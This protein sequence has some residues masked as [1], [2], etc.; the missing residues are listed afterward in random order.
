MSRSLLFTIVLVAPLTA[1]DGNRLTYLDESDPYHV[2][3]AFPRLTTPQWVGEDGV[4]AVVVLAIDDMRGHEKWEAYLRPILNRLKRIDGRAPVSIM[5]C[6]IEPDEAHLQK[7]LAE[8]LSLETHT[9]DHPCPILQKGDLA[10][11]KATYDKCVDLLASVPGSKPVAFRTP[12]CDSLNTPSP[13][14]FAI[15]FNGTTAK[16]NYLTIDTSVFNIFTPDDPELPRELVLE[17]GRSRFAKYLPRD[18]AFGNLI[19]N[20]PYPY[21][22]GRLCWEFPCVTP[23]DWQAQHLHKPN[24]PLTIRDWQAAL[25]ATV[26]KQGVFCMVFHPHGWIKNEQVIDF[27]EHAVTRHGKKVKFL[28]FAECQKRLD[29]HLLG[30]QPLRSA[31][32]ADNGIRLLDLNGDGFMDVVIGND[33]VKQ[34]RIWDSRKKAW[35]TS[36]F[37]VSL[38]QGKA[39]FGIIDTYPVLLTHE[40]DRIA[41]WRFDGKKWAPEKVDWTS[42]QSALA[43]WPGVR[44]RDLD[45]DGTCELIVGMGNEG[46]VF[47]WDRGN[48][49]WSK[50]PFALPKGTAIADAKGNDAGL[51]F[52]DVDEDGHDDVLVSN[53]K[54]YGLWLFR[55]MKEGWSQE[56]C[57]GKGGGK[58][59]LP[60]IARNGTNNG[61]WFLDG[62]LWVQN[63]DTAALKDLVQRVSF[64]D[65]LKDVQPGPK[66]PEASQRCLK[67]SPGFLAELVAAE[68]LVQDPIA[69]AWGPDGKF[70]VVEMGDYPLGVDAKGRHGGRVKFLEDTDGDGKY[71]RSTVF[72]DGLGYPTGVTPWRQGV[73]VTCAPD[74]LYAEDLDGDGKADRRL[75]VYTGFGEGNQQHRVNTLAWGLDNWLHVANGDSD[76]TIRSLKSKQMVDIRGR[77]L[78]IRPDTGAVDAETG[79]TQF[80]RSRDD[81]GNWFGGNNSNPMWHFALADHYLR[82]NPHVAPPNLRVPVPAVPGNSPVFPR[83]RT[84]ARFNDYHTANRFTS[85]CSPIVYR[86]ELFGPAFKDNVFISEPVHNLVHREVMSPQG[87]TFRSTRAA[88]EEQA[89][90]LASSDNWFRP[91]MIRTG[92]DGA[93]W[94]ADM[95]RHVIEHPQWIPKDWQNRLD[96]RAGHDRGRIYRVYPVG[97]K[98]RAIPRF[99]RLVLADLVQVLDSPNG[100]QRD[101]VQQML[102]WKQSQDAIPMLVK[103]AREA[104]R[105]HTRLHALCTLDGLNA[106]SSALLVHVLADEHPGVRRHAVRL[107]EPLLA[108]SPE[109]GAALLKLTGDSDAQVRLQLACTLGEWD[110][111]QAGAGLGQLL[112]KDPDDP[113]LTT[114]AYSSVNATNL[115]ATLQAVLTNGGSPSPVSRLLRLADALGQKEALATLL[116]RV[117]SPTPEGFLPWQ[118]QALGGLLDN[119]KQRGTSFT[120]LVVKGPKSAEMQGKFDALLLAARKSAVD[121]KA[122]VETRSASL[123]VLGRTEKAQGED[124][125][126]FANLLVPRSPEGLQLAAVSALARSGNRKAASV[127]LERWG[128]YSPAI[129]AQVLDVLLQRKESTL[130]VLDAVANKQVHI[131]EIDTPRRQRLVDHRDTAIRDRA[132]KVLAG[133]I[134]LDRQKVIDLYRKEAIKGDI[135]RGKAVFSK[136]CIACHQFRGEGKPIGADL[137]SLTDKSPDAL[138]TAILDPNRAI[139]AKF[140]NY[141][142][143]MKDGRVLVGLLLSET[144]TSITLI[145][146]DGK[147]LVLLRN[148]LESLTSTGKSAMPEGFEK[149][150]KPQDVADVIAYL[151]E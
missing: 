54:A 120:E 36:D 55:S 49:G 28:T 50:C 75:P 66:S 46:A 47:A 131:A 107:S 53:E 86:D 59:A 133:A 24:N 147:E 92:P 149:E 27:I 150:L 8:G 132:R 41:S 69:F 134:D 108:K 122:S 143:E 139:E 77:D 141:V 104:K 87:F 63:E 106:L 2:S 97:A 35:Q 73:L 127:L 72:L 94:V 30:G 38:H 90:F 126:L 32:G 62:Q 91:T 21:V 56:I 142:V 23:S 60:M 100:W 45:A 110:D 71:D 113:Y 12:C 99:D 58:D 119:L 89:E 81:W 98:P 118:F 117:L 121:E 84:L 144:A 40:G 76:G 44:L 115:D 14:M 70:W 128:G 7:W 80:G 82:R 109:L 83:S 16:G 130:L 129:R 29:E 4:E 135:A 64:H 114:A 20:Y 67:A 5:T 48:P 85:A 102:I 101:M 22:L 148:D 112:T 103:L 140:V 51:R 34:T 57:A 123:A 125:E 6:K 79:R 33:A 26:V 42:A 96:L 93:L 15:I 124:F 39:R 18:R 116:D 13:R 31:K 146:P 111:P 17:E 105:P 25:D 37:P 52:V 136:H 43:N 88:G 19:E 95:Y 68:P 61:A 1:G 9:F 74:I 3:R 138:M 137:A 11:A 65:M 151:R 145:G 78:R 10:A